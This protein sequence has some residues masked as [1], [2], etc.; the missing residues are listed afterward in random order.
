MGGEAVRAKVDKIQ[1]TGITYHKR[2]YLMRKKE[3]L[4]VVY[5]NE[6]GNVKL[7]NFY[8]FARQSTKSYITGGYKTAYKKISVD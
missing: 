4:C 2:R 1:L 5:L 8:N 7:K 3:I 6:K